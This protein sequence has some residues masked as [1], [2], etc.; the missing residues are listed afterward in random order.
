MENITYDKFVQNILN[1][2]GRFACGNEYH[3][4]HHI[5]PKCMGGTNDKD[6]LIDLFA[7]EHFEAHRLLALENPENDKLVYAWWAMC[8]FPG[9]SKQ[10]DNVTPEEYEE[11]R[12]VCSK[13]ASESLRGENHPNYG[14]H[15]FDGEKNPFYGQ[16]HSEES[17]KK[18]SES[19]RGKYAGENHPRALSVVQCN[20]NDNLIKIWVYIERAANELQIIKSHISDCCKG[21]RKTAGGYC[22]HYLYDQTQKDGTVILG[23]IT[24]GLIPEEE[25]LRMLKEQK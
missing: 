3:E 14:T 9:S 16:R 17:K 23:A 1:T 8:T 19:K 12:K 2:R 18:M 11:V 13:I 21:K 20:L 7:R 15:K 10:R 22:W 4:R 24:L 6:N 25:A 5:I